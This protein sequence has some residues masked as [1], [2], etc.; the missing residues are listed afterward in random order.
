M[1]H[2]FVESA[3]ILIVRQ[4]TQARQARDSIATV[5]YAHPNSG[6]V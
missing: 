3:Y 4:D 1:P 6:F 5:K 2:D